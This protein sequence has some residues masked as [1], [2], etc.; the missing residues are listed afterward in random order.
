MVTSQSNLVAFH[1]LTCT[2]I[3]KNILLIQLW[4]Q[5]LLKTLTVSLHTSLL[6]LLH[7]MIDFYYCRYP[8]YLFDAHILQQHPK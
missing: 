6:R 8:P 1:M 5:S 3:I 7:C 4:Y 2:D